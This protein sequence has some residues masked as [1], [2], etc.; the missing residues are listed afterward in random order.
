M[1][2][3]TEIRNRLL[4]DLDQARQDLYGA[5]EGLDP[6]REIYPGWT[7]K[8][9]CAHLTGWDEAVAAALRAHAGGQEPGTPAVAGVDFYNA[10]SVAT[11]QDLSF[12]Q[13]RAECDLARN[14]V[15]EIL[16]ELPAAK[17]EEPLL[18]P[19]GPTGTVAELIA[20]FVHHERGHA[21]EIRQGATA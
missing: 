19:W 12:P 11:R 17:F 18:F 16:R 13:V 8:H 14:Q 7:M 2:D 15:K 10:Q 6:G 4:K 9:V 1:N 21:A 5:M 3:V 20:V